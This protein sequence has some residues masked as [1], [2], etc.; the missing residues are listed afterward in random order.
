MIGALPAARNL[1]SGI[2]EHFSI[3]LRLIDFRL[4]AEK[5]IDVNNLEQLSA[6][7]RRALL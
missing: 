4:N 1:A 2:R 5:L 6:P 7:N 3:N